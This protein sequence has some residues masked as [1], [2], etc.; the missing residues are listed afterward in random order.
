MRFLI[1][2]FANQ[3]IRRISLTAYGKSV[4]RH[5]NEPEKMLERIPLKTNIRLVKNQIILRWYEI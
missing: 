4:K 1:Q 5:Q 2:Y 3:A